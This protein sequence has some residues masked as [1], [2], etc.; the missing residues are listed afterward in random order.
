MADSEGG[1]IH[2]LQ[3]RPG[4]RETQVLGVFG[5]QQQIGCFIRER[6]H[7]PR[8]IVSCRSADDVDRAD[9]QVFGLP[10]KHQHCAADLNLVT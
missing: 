2:H 6:T 9:R 1:A 10:T 5:Y 4:T 7:D 8:M 3:V